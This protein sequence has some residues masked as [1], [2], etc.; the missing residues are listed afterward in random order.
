MKTVSRSRTRWLPFALVL[1]GACTCAMSANQ[2]VTPAQ[3]ASTFV[4]VS[5]IPPYGVIGHDA[6]MASATVLPY[7]TVNHAT[8]RPSQAILPYGAMTRDA[9]TASATVLPYGAVGPRAAP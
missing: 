8:A 5:T 9:S 4:N 7:G 1:V 2:A 3:L 6:A